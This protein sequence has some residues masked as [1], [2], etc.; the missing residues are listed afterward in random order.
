MIKKIL[1]YTLLAVVLLIGTLAVNLWVFTRASKVV[2]KG[3]PIP[4]YENGRSALLVVDIQECTTG[5]VSTSEDLKSQSEWLIPM[6]N[7]LTRRAD[8]LGIP[9]VFIRSELTNPLLNILN[10]SMA[11]GSEGA[12]LDHRLSVGESDPVIT[13]SRSD[14]F[15]NPELDRVLGEMGVDHIYLTGLDAAH[16]VDNTFLGALN[17]GYRITVIADAVISA[18]PDIR[19]GKI[20]EF[21][22]QGAQ[23]IQS[24]DFP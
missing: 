13:K 23:I 2:S 6:I 5:T 24:K 21:Q 3:T 17:R 16:C 11:R 20:K 22:A 10:N 4:V 7:R 1:L 8:S 19:D 14:A 12:K 9:V 18:P 15:S